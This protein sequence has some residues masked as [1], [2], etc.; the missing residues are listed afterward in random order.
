M[1][2][3]NP[4]S[5]LPSSRCQRSSRRAVGGRRPARPARIGA[6]YIVRRGLKWDPIRAARPF[7]G[8]AALLV[9]ALVGSG[10]LASIRDLETTPVPAGDPQVVTI[11][12][13]LD[14]RPTDLARLGDAL[15]AGVI[16]PAGEAGNILVV[17]ATCSR[18]ASL[19]PG[20]ACNPERPFELP[21]ETGR[22]LAEKSFGVP[23]EKVEL[24]P[25]EEVATSGSA[26]VL[27]NVP[28]KTLED[29][30]KVAAMRT[31]PVPFV[32]SALSNVTVR[33]PLVPWLVGGILGAGIVLAVGCFVSL[34]GRLLAARKHHRQLLNLG[35]VPRRLV[36]MEAWL[37]ALPYCVVATVSFLA[38]LAI[39]VKLLGVFSGTPMP[40]HDIGV[41]MIVVGV[42]GVLGTA[43]VAV[44]GAR[45]IQ[46]N[47]E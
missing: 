32:G 42:I 31:L 29:R 45:G 28:L 30:V 8:Y 34:V 10:Y 25:P 7:T 17:G 14:P 33:S 44:F 40:W 38:G 21:A 39:C 26:L 15:G 23:R 47:P 24:V 4:A 3:W 46:E 37:F 27:D 22:M 35:L 13:W 11:S 5:R 2:K 1:R 6:G 19:F 18:L 41:I 43:S 12:S 20:T 9:I 36:A 16:L